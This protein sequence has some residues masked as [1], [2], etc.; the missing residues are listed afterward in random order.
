V[1]RLVLDTGVK[2]RVQVPELTTVRV[3][4][5]DPC[6]AS[7]ITIEWD[8]AVFFGRTGS[9]TYHVYRVD[10]AAGRCPVP[11]VLGQSTGDPPLVLGLT[12]TT[13]AD[14]TALPGVAYRYLVQ[15]EDATSNSC[16]RGPHNNGPSASA[17]ADATVTDTVGA[18]GSADPGNALRLARAASDVILDWSTTTVT[19]QVGEA[20]GALWSASVQGPWTLLD[21]GRLAAPQATDT[22]AGAATFRCYRATVLSPEGCPAPDPDRP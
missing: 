1:A 2:D 9:G 15:A 13:F 18:L 20:W 14:A 6:A 12:A 16:V 3:R 22:G 10:G 8:P 21:P 5:A 4:D 19:L 17:C 11:F 7:G